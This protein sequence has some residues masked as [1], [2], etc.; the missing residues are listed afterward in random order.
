M[1]WWLISAIIVLIASLAC[2]LS[3][4]YEISKGKQLKPADIWGTAVFHGGTA[5]LGIWLLLKSWGKM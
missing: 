4:A 1:N 3:T 5:L 2:A